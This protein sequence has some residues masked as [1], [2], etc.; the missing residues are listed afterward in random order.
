MGYMKSATVVAMLAILAVVPSTPLLAQSSPFSANCTDL[1]THAN[2]K[3]ALRRAL[4]KCSAAILPASFNAPRCLSAPSILN[5][6]TLHTDVGARVRF[7]IQGKNQLFGDVQGDGK[8]NGADL[9]AMKNAL[10]STSVD[11]NFS[12]ETDLNGD[13]VVDPFDF[14]LLLRNLRPTRLNRYFASNL[15]KGLSLRKGVVNG[16]V[17]TAGSYSFT[18]GMHSECGRS[19]KII[20]L[21]VN[22]NVPPTPTV[23]P[24]SSGSTFVISSIESDP[25]CAMSPL[26]QI[27]V[28]SGGSVTFKAVAQPGFTV[29]DIMVDGKSQGSMSEW[30]FKEVAAD[31]TIDAHCSRVSN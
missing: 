8:V 17:S 20:D 3:F 9:T 18:V 21:L 15:P 13:G 11:S 29:S 25:A 19:T 26:G 12:Y 16:Q 23:T 1:V 30:T 7:E 6:T 31:H 22:S 27:K 14:G 5:E 24:T 2:N 4:H 10:G 28:A